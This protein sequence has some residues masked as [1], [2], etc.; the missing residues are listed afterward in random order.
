M[1]PVDIADAKPR[2][3]QLIDQ[4]AAGEDVVIS[5]NGQPLVRLTRPDAPRVVRFGLLSGRLSIPDDFDASL[6][7]DVLAAF[8]AR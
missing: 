6:P 1:E 3:S 5:R 4:A 2:F 7:A 8:G